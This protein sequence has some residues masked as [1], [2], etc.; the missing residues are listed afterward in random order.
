MSFC[1][2]KLSSCIHRQRCALSFYYL[3]LSLYSI[4]RKFSWY[5]Y[6][7][8]L[9]CILLTVYT[10]CCQHFYFLNSRSR[11][12]FTIQYIL[13]IKFAQVKET[14]SRD[15]SPIFFG[16]KRFYLGPVWIGK[17]SF[18]NFFV[19]AKIFT[20]NVCPHSQRLHW[21]PFQRSH[22]LLWHRVSIVNDY[23]DTVSL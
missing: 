5:M 16:L 1:S 3:K 14:V 2:L 4:V 6:K 15:F 11:S 17:N 19:F 7:K 12:T 21:H 10:C 22:W 8:N 13:Y 18:A 20:K 9:N 23:A